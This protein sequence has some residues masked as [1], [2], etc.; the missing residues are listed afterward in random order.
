MARLE[1]Q[2][3]TLSRTVVG[4]LVCALGLAPEVAKAGD[5]HGHA[6]RQ[7]PTAG[8]PRTA[9]G[10]PSLEGVWASNALLLLEATSK[11]P[12]LVVPEAEAKVLAA[13]AA[14]QM[15]DGFDRGLDPEAPAM[16]RSLDGFP[17]VRGERRTRLVVEPADGK[18][19]YTPAARRETQSPPRQSF[20][21]PEDRP[22]PERCLSGV[23]T[24][25]MTTLNYANRLR[26]VQTRDHV[27]LQSEYGD[28]V[29]I[30]P[31]TSAHRP[32]ALTSQLGD[33][34][35]RWEGDTL[36]IE[37]VGQPDANR[38]HMFP[39]L[40]VTGE[41]TV[42]ERLTRVSASELDYQFT[43]IDPKTFSGP[44]LGEFSWF[45]TNQPMF[46]HACHE[47]NYSLPNILA[48]ARHSEAAA[49]A[50]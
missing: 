9:D 40:L 43:V 17:L 48:G 22:T 8:P 12:K 39:T 5:A 38:R 42:I 34:I 29:R 14:E 2:S 41:A 26:I 11:T 15:A 24:P 31:F 1:G 28:D 30:A 45:R 10:R 13:A 44:W 49:A 33:S 36:V 46:E 3:V 19:P 20:D 6:A 7:A 35:A 25:P 18:V 37:T 27:V 32:K 50:R 23:G 16:L 4:L 21:N 47:G